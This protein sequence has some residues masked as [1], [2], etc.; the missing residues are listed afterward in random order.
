MNLVI[1]RT[2][3][4]NGFLFF[5]FIPSY[6]QCHSFSCIAPDSLHGILICTQFIYGLAVYRTDLIIIAKASLFR[7]GSMGNGF[8]P[9]VM[10]A[11]L[12]FLI[13]DSHAD[14][15]SGIRCRVLIA[16]IIFRCHIRGPPVSQTLCITG[17]RT[18]NQIFCFIFPDKILLCNGIDFLQC[19]IQFSQLPAGM[20]HVI[21]GQS[22]H[23]AARKCC[24]YPYRQCFAQRYLFFHVSA[25]F[26]S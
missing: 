14:A 9:Q 25:S 26:P 22:G 2:G 23:Q 19:I 1:F 11:I 13:A 4:R 8:H 24:Q 17:Q 16:F 15:H 5:R 10:A 3:N 18:I 6:T 20:Y 7:R 12:P 21:D